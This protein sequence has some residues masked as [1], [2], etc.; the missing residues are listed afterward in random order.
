[1]SYFEENNKFLSFKGVV[2]RRDFV[3][4][5][6]ILM[7]IS[8]IIYQTPLMYAILIK[9]E[10]MHTLSSSTPPM[11]LSVL[12]LVAGTVIGALFLPA[13]VRRIRDILGEE[14]DSK[15]YLIAIA[16]FAFGIISITPV[17]RQMGLIIVDFIIDL[18]LI[19]TKGKI[20]GEKPK[21]DIIK[22]NWGAFLGTWFWGIWNRVYKTLWMIPLLFTPGWFVFMLICGLKGNEWAYEKNKEKYDS[23][24]G[25]HSKQSTQS[26]VFTVLTPVFALVC[27]IALSFVTGITISNYAKN[28]PDFVSSV[29][30]GLLKYQQKATAANFEKIE[31]TDDVYKFYIDPKSWQVLSK[32]GKSLFFE[33]ALNYALIENNKFQTPD[34]KV[35]DYLGIAKKIKIISSFNNETLLEFTPT[36]DEEKELIEYSNNKDFRNFMAVK[37][38]CMKINP[39]PTLP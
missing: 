8:S 16:C 24:E 25:F 4:L 13:V 38:S 37:K 2:G 26:I 10:L 14:N 3:V 15:I 39:T 7:L 19:F 36:E 6:L 5:Y 20:T 12:M 35:E 1:M 9:P 34:A 18:I 21:S 17:G 31:M 29:N 11:W 27:F 32:G 23:V 33:N 22:F 28:H 30:A